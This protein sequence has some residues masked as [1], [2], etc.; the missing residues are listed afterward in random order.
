MALKIEWSESSAKQL[1]NI[2]NYYLSEA[3]KRVADRIIDKIIE[4]V[5]ILYQNPFAG[6]KEEFLTEYPEEFRYL[7]AG[8]YKVI[9]W[10]GKNIITIAS[11]FDCRQ[12]PVKMKKLRSDD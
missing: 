10:I 4:R 1:Q 7:V 3:G 5:D 2:Y 12:D 11:V 8:N 6:A 9:Y